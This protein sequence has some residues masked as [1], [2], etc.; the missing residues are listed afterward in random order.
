MTEQGPLPGKSDILV[1][2]GGPAGSC[3]ATMLARRG[4]DVVIVD[5]VRHPRETVGESVLPSAW[6]YFDMLG[7]S[8]EVSRRFVK[9]A[10]GVVVWGDEITQ[11]AFRDFAYDR[12][13][14]HVER[15]DLD[16]LLLTNATKS[17]A[18]LFEGVRAESF[19]STGDDGAEVALVIDG[20]KRS[21]ACRYLI[22][23]TGQAS[24]V[25]RQLVPLHRGFDELIVAG[26]QGRQRFGIDQH[27]DAPGHAG[28]ASDQP[29]AFERE[30]HLVD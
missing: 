8:D 27:L 3:A 18:R 19:R 24:F 10:G 17:G 20:E 14:L 9:K 23:A 13:G 21:L 12:P 29:A 11:I 30:H 15:A 26:A 22:D 2:G 4:Y 7:V 1:V 5:K 25:A 6:K 16:H 28:L